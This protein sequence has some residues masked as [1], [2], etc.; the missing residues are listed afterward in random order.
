[1]PDPRRQ[2]GAEM[3][4]KKDHASSS[5]MQK[6]GG[7]NSF[8]R[9]EN[10][11]PFSRIDS[12]AEG[13]G[14][15]MQV[16]AEDP[17]SSP[18]HGL[19]EEPEDVFEKK[20]PE[21]SQGEGEGA[22]PAAGQPPPAELPEQF[23]E[24]PIELVSLTDSTPPSI[25][26]LSGLFQDFYVRAGSH[27]ST[28]VSTLASRLHR[29]SSASSLQSQASR[30][31]RRPTSSHG[32]QKDTPEQ[33]MLTAEEV[34]EKR[35]ARKLLQFKQHALEEAVE[36]RA[37][38]TIYDKIWRHRSTIDDVRDEKLR[39]KT[40][41]L[42]VMGIELKDLGVDISKQ[43]AEETVDPKECVAAARQCL[44]R[45][46]DER[47]PLGKLQQLVA[48]HKAIVDA[49]TNILPSSSSA[50]E[51]LPTL[52]Y[53]LILSPPEGVNIISNLNFIQRFRS[54]SKIDGETAYCLTNLEAA[55][56]FLENV[57][58]TNL[59]MEEGRAPIDQ[60]DLN[61]LHPAPMDSS[62]DEAL[63]KS[64][65]T[66]SNTTSTAP[67]ARPTLP[68]NPSAQQRLSDLFQPPAKA[69]GAANDIVRSTADQGLKSI[70]STLDNSFA[71][72]FGRL[73]EVQISQGDNA[74]PG[75]PIVPKTLDDARK[76]VQVKA[77]TV[78][79]D[80]A[81][82]E[83]GSNIGDRTPTPTPSISSRQ[84]LDDRLAEL[85]GG[86]R[87]PGTTKRDSSTNRSDTNASD[88]TAASSTATPPPTIP[89]STGSTNQGFGSVRGFGT[90]LNPLSHFPSMIRGLARAPDPAAA[91]SS[92][93]AKSPGPSS[94]T[95]GAPGIQKF[96][97]MG[98]ASELKV[99]DIP[100]L[101][102][103]YKRLAAILKAQQNN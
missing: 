50:D 22:E 74:R 44:I 5:Q 41:A 87:R 73:K 31:S 4:E 24:L 57:D 13:V 88:D 45:M 101:L 78:Q 70:S 62:S 51:I 32:T 92:T 58:L 90:S 36:R 33:Q 19:V 63:E 72:L 6:R 68:T 3:S 42:L 12:T 96:L 29:N 15:A 95:K 14:E 47:Y 7:S 94:V 34:A 25:D 9:L 61:L 69:L 17:L 83:D 86:R 79:S 23:A 1:M 35:K 53:T 67:S 60:P 30:S 2:E 8:S 89:S 27:I 55:I 52:I 48:A 54:S 103:D 21:G 66:V 85:V 93:R 16:V 82:S 77:G 46:N 11:S 75:T 40:A 91:T 71:F 76:L 59:R 18:G 39:S 84:P 65:S 81:V 102:E 80:E 49:L 97:D 64:P 56:D 99:G 37:C 100:E 98:D 28:H 43:G 38:E 20:A 26:T 10:S